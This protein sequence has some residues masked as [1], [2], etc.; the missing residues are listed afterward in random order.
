MAKFSGFNLTQKNGEEIEYNILYYPFLQ[1]FLHHYPDDFPCH[2]HLSHNFK[3]QIRLDLP[4]LEKSLEEIC[5]V[6]R[7]NRSINK[8]KFDVKKAKLPKGQ[9]GETTLVYANEDHSIGFFLI[10][11]FSKT[12]EFLQLNGYVHPKFYLDDDTELEEKVYQ[13]VWSA[14][15]HT[16]K[17]EVRPLYLVGANS[18]GYSVIETVRPKP[19][20]SDLDLHY[21]EGFADYYTELI[22]KLKRNQKGLVILHGIPGSGKTQCIRDMIYELGHQKK[23]F[24]VTPDMVSRIAD[25]DFL[26]FLIRQISMETMEEEDEK[27]ESDDKNYILF[28]EDCEN[29]VHSRDQGN[30]SSGIINLLNATDGILNDIL[31]V[32]VV[33]TFNTQEDNLDAALLRNGRL[34]SKKFFGYLSSQQIH[35]FEKKY[36]IQLPKKDVT[37]GDV[38]AEKNN[39]TQTTHT[40]EKPERKFG[41]IQ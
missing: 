35:E 22:N 5:G 29:L 6:K 37:L 41:F 26:T 13:A 14:S 24:Y 19:V 1:G 38:Y 15:S 17:K 20:F 10:V 9:Y 32:Q 34:L 16:K 25:P 2:F 12:T 28:I 36:A 8:I 40:V 30:Y 11:N 23:C 21:G 31:S 33:L 3:I 27:E 4:A 7:V 18:T 39:N